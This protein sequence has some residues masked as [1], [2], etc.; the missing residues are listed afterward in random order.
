MK[1]TIKQIA[2]NGKLARQATEKQP[3]QPLYD[4]NDF[5]DGSGFIRT[6]SQLRYY[7]DLYLYGITTDAMWIYQLIIDWYNHEDGSAYPSQYV[8]ARRL[9]KSVATVK[10]HISALRSVG[11]ISVQSRGIGRSNLYL[12]LKPLDKQ[13]MYERFPLAKQF[14]DEHEALIDKYEGIDKATIEP[15]KKRQDEKK[16]EVAAEN[17]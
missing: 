14:A 12:P 5:T 15:N 13:T 4:K 1:L 8:I 7:T 17:K 3:Q 6:P 11:L 9:R 16:A 2:E 10:K